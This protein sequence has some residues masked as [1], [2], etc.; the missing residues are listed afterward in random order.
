MASSPSLSRIATLA[1][2]LKVEDVMKQEFASVRPTDMMSDLG[3]VVEKHPSAEIVVME[4]DEVVGIVD[5]E[6]VKTWLRHGNDDS[7]ISEKMTPAK[8]ALYQDLPLATTFSYFE[9]CGTRFPVF[10]RETHNLAGTVARCDIVVGLL[11]KTEAL[12]QD[13]R[14]SPAD[15][16]PPLLSGIR[17]DGY[18]LSLT[19]NVTSQ[20]L[21]NAGDASNRLKKTLKWLCLP[22]DVVQRAAIVAYE[23]EMNMVIYSEGGSLA[24][25][26]DSEKIQIIAS[27]RGPGIPDIPQAMAPG[28]STAPDWVRELGFGAGMGLSNIDQHADQ[29]DLQSEPGKGVRL[30]TSIEIA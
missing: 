13:M 26:V 28:F 27:D 1:I 16:P 20:D 3:A 19:Y 21:D 17:A 22:H 4:Q 30:E 18:G 9:E 6:D 2:G 25:T 7:P 24:I 11:K 14:D 12:A 23:A 10:D 15:E 29:M 5:R 8:D